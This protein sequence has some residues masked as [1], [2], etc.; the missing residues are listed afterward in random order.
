MGVSFRVRVCRQVLL[1]RD[2]RLNDVFE[3]RLRHVHNRS[4]HIMRGTV[5]GT[6]GNGAS[7]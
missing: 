2:K 4:R 3:I 1:S 7:M 6:T 5:Y